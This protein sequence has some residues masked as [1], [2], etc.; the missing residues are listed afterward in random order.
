MEVFLIILVLVVIFIFFVRTLK[1]KKSEQIIE[2]PVNSNLELKNNVYMVVG[3]NYENEDDENIQSI[4]KQLTEEYEKEGIIKS[5]GGM[6]DKKLVKTF[7]EGYFSHSIDEFENEYIFNGIKLVPDPSNKHDENA[8]KVY[9]KDTND[10]FYHVGYISKED[11]VSL[12]NKMEKRKIEKTIL[13][14]KGGNTKAIDDEDYLVENEQD[15]WAIKVGII[16][17][18]NKY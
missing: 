13:E 15:I 14:F 3:T 8:I 12:K 7:K 2:K 16:F 10:V 9:I 11:N 5:F 17:N 1:Q 6:T 4:I 18:W